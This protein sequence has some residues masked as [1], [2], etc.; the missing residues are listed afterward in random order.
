MVG[1]KWDNTQTQNQAINAHLKHVHQSPDSHQ[2][3]DAVCNRT[4]E[5]HGDKN[6]PLLPNQHLPGRREIACSQRIEI[7]TTRH[8]VHQN[9]IATIPIRRTT[10]TPIQTYAA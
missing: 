6:S 8:T 3:V 7:Q 4:L 10:P 1:W 9:R 5:K 2:E